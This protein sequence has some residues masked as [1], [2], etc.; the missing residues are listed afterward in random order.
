MNPV[1]HRDVLYQ[2]AGEYHL[3]PL[4]VAAVIAAESKFNPIATSKKRALGLMQLMPATAFE[5]AKELG[6]DI[7]NEEELYQ[8]EVNIRLGCFYLAKLTKVLKGHRVLTLAAYNAGLTPV[9]AWARGYEGIS[10]EELIRRMPFAETR[11]FVTSVLETYRRYQWLQALR[12]R[13]RFWQ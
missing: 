6:L 13:L 4:L 3:D 9:R 7:V 12:Q 5:M 8:P 11:R 1:F 10:D 2:W